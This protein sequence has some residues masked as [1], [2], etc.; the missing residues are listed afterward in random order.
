MLV[1]LR[2]IYVKVKQIKTCLAP[3]FDHLNHAH[4]KPQYWG[5]NCSAGS[6][7]LIPIVMNL[8]L[9][10][11]FYAPIMNTSYLRPKLCASCSVVVVTNS[12]NMNTQL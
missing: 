3:G 1:Y 12:L 10:S 7:N 8:F 11:D 5:N 6:C 4:L 9:K 2:V